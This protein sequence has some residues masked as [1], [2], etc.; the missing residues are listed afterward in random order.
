MYIKSA[1]DCRYIGVT[2]YN[3]N[4]SGI[5]RNQRMEQIC[6]SGSRRTQT[7]VGKHDK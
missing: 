5:E 2:D 7:G 4:E 1:K 3:P 6:L